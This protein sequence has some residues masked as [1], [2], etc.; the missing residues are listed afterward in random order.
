MKL[1]TE[2]MPNS[3]PRAIR[4]LGVKS[5]QRTARPTWRPHR[6]GSR[7]QRASAFAQHLHD[8]A[9]GP[10]KRALSSA[11]VRA[12]VAQSRQP[13]RR[14]AGRG[15]QPR[16]GS[17]R[18]G[19]S[20]SLTQRTMRGVERLHRQPVARRAVHDHM[21]QRVHRRGTPAS[22]AP[23]GRVSCSARHAPSRKNGSRRPIMTRW[24]AALWLVDQ[25]PA[26]RASG[27]GRYSGRI[28][29]MRQNSRVEPRLVR[30]AE[31]R[32]H[33]GAERA[34]P[35]ESESKPASFRPNWRITSTRPSW[36]SAT[37]VVARLLH[38]PRTRGSTSTK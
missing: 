24:L 35:A 22:R 28:F 31:L 13:A 15:A 16:T 21:Q 38:R 29:T 1:C 5:C 9:E 2:V 23:A 3:G 36:I 33:A 37:A 7:T 10:A 17:R 8:V 20:S 34:P 18:F 4:R 30:L 27:K 11:A 26:K 32:A 19:C 12:S 14:N 6:P 25:R